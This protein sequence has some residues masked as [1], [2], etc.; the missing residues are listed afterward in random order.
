M[1][2]EVG[3]RKITVRIPE[4]MYLEMKRMVEEAE[5]ESISSIVREALEIFM[6]KFSKGIS[7]GRRL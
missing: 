4:S 5:A 6:N 7:G 3:M 2:R 1:A